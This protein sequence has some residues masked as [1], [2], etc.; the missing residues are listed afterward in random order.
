MA[1]AAY[2]GHVSTLAMVYVRLAGRE[3]RA[4]IE[5]FGD[6]YRRYKEVTPGWIPK[7]T[8][9]NQ[10][11]NERADEKSMNKMIDHD[12]EA[13]RHKRPESPSSHSSVP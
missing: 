12:A 11:T 8:I 10:S 5:I 13:N 7:L 2:T 6:T 9:E 1:Y 3:E 4:A